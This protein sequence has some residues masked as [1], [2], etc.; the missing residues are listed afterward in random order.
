MGLLQSLARALRTR[1]AEFGNRRPA[2]ET[3]VAGKALEDLADPAWEIL[4][5]V[6]PWQVAGSI[7][8]YYSACD[9]ENAYRTHSLVMAC[10]R[11]I[12]TSISEP[13][14]M[15]VEDAFAD[16]APAGAVQPVAN[17]PLLD[18]LDYPNDFYSRHDLIS[19]WTA[20]LMLTGR[21]YLWKWRAR[22]GRVAQLWPI[23]TSWVREIPG[24]GNNLIDHYEVL[25]AGVRGAGY[26]PAA[27]TGQLSVPAA[28]MVRVALLD[29][30]TMTQGVSPLQAAQHDYQ[31]DMER[32]NYLVEMLTNLHVPGLKFKSPRK[33]TDKERQELR[34]AMED[35]FGLGKRGAPLLVENGSD[36]ELMEPLKD[37]DWPGLTGLTESRICSAF[38]V[39]PILVGA[40][41]GLDRSTYANY[42]EARRSFY[43]ETLKP[44]WAAL[45]CA[46]THWLLKNEGES[47]LRVRFDLSHIAELQE[48][49]TA[50]A[51]RA[52]ED[53]KA[54]LIT[55]N[56][57]RAASGWPAADE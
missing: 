13:P 46:L 57:A 55:R 48:D 20:R 36:A 18:L 38:G 28:D 27:R 34:A 16:A 2:T 14:L 26:Q 32:Q 56:E 24:G 51:A 5:G 12:T 7:W 9:L 15:M 3:P 47:G 54:G 29:P 42:A 31:L 4:S 23:P 50:R 43:S 41:V 22:S 49:Q 25:Q 39:P 45:E 19:Y 10:V 1:N 35:R 37:M 6:P 17:H 30:G 11:A 33:L 8:R 52:R 44:L 40:R 21:G 53:W